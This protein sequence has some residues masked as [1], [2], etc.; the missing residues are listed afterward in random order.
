[1]GETLLIWL[2]VIQGALGA[3]AYYLIVKH[4]WFDHDDDE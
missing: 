4:I 1:M 3:G 2:L